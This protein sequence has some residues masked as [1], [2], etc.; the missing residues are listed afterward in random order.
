MTQTN[1]LQI[2]VDTTKKARAYQRKKEK[3]NTEEHKQFQQEAAIYLRVSSE[4]QKE[5][6]S[7][8]AQKLACQRCVQEKGFH[9]SEDHIY[10]DEAF[11][12]KNEDRPAFRKMMVDA[13]MKQ[14]SLLNI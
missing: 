11:T 13:Y 3:K 9:L 12:A 1:Y 7:I 8:E 6:F 10:I 14:F 5:G 4:M 2:D